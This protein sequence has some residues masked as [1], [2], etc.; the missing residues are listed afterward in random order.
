MQDALVGAKAPGFELETAGPG[1]AQG[2]VSLA[3][4]AGTWTVVYIYPKDS[5]PG[6]T[7]EAKEFTELLPRFQ[8]LGARVLGL[9]R[10]SLKAHRNFIDKQGLGLELASDPSLE[11]LKALG[12]WGTKTVC[13]KSCEGV[14]RSTLLIAPDGTVARRWPKAPSKGHAAEVLAALAELAGK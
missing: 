8:A 12:G 13:G 3:G 10:D 5:T 7:T 6:C 4:L 9:S 1:G 2:R 11:T 14:I